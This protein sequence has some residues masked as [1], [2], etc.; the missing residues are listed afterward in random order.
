MPAGWPVRRNVSNAMDGRMSV[1]S[2]DVPLMLASSTRPISLLIRAWKPV[3][4][5]NF[6]DPDDVAAPRWRIRTLSLSSPLK[7]TAP[8][9]PVRVLAAA[10]LGANQYQTGSVVVTRGSAIIVPENSGELTGCV[11]S[12][13]REDW[14]STSVAVKY[15]RTSWPCV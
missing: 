4:K 3:L 1:G 12:G 6:R 5:S 13:H 8:R 14:P 10:V 2:D 9:I 7:K 11:N 15:Q